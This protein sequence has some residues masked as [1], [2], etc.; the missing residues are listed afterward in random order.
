MTTTV[1]IA[2]FT[3]AFLHAFWNFI[4]RKT[5]NKALGM[6]GVILGHVILGLIGIAYAGWPPIK[7]LP[8][9]VVSGIFH[10]MYQVFLLNAYRRGELTQ[11]YPIARGTAPL[12][13]AVLSI[14]IFNVD[15]TP[16]HLIG[17]SV[18]SV[19]IITH[20]I[21]EYQRNHAHIKSLALA[22]MVGLCIAS[23][24]MVDGHGTRI[25]GSALS[26]YGASSLMNAIF[27]I[28]YL[29]VFEKGVM[30]KLLKPEG[31]KLLLIGGSASYLAY[32]MVLWAILSVPIAVVSSMRETSV[33]FAL[34]LGVVVLKE[35]LTI[36]KIMLSVGILAGIFILN[37]S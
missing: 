25:A 13:I 15:L 18:I 2:I 26:F 6:A 10:L 12:I 9:I 31:L 28:P 35:R 16:S 24:S 23:Y 34:L 22:M 29:M 14:T 27:F 30:G 8:F 36:D 32:V 17:I 1:A 3:A 20:G 33:L 21:I 7:S 19:S 4:V 5:D 11:V 37:M